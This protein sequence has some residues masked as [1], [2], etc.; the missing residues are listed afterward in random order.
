MDFVQ[1]VRN[2]INATMTAQVAKVESTGQ[3][4]DIASTTILTPDTTWFFRVSVYMMTTT[5][6]TG[7]L[8]CTIAFTDPEG[9]KTISPAGSV[10]LSDAAGGS[11]GNEFIVSVASA[12]S[13]STAIAGKSGNPKYS[14]YILL[15]QLG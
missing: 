11:T 13:F 15:E 4:G 3:T 6:G 9:A 8:T 10:D 7:T 14:L 2:A 1:E 5:T 12:I